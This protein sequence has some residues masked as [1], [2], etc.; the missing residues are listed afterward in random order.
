MNLF[1]LKQ[2]NIKDLNL[3]RCKLGN[4]GARYVIDALNRNTTIRHLNISFND[5]SSSVYEFSIKFSSMLT[6]H[7]TLMHADITNCGFKREESMF[8]ILAMSTSKNF[9]SL[10]LTGNELPYYE[11]VFMR[12]LI[13]ARL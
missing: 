11:R 5:L 10:H 8:V 2:E 12:A 7:P 6:R 13:S 4:Q 3:A 9:L 1:L